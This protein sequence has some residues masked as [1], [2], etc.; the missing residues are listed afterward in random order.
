MAT[1]TVSGVVALGTT[2][3]L[4][5]TATVSA[6]AGVVD[7]VPG[8]NTA[9]DTNPTGLLSAD[10]GVTVTP[11]AASVTSGA[12]VGYALQ[13]VNAGA[14]SAIGTVV[15]FSIPGGAGFVSAAGAGW[16]CSLSGSTVTCALA[17]PVAGGASAPPIALDLLAPAALGPFTL[18][19]AVTSATADPNPAND[20]AAASVTVTAASSGGGGATAAPAADL[21]ITKSVDRALAATGDR[22]T[23]TLQVANAGPDP[24]ADVVVTDTLPDA[25]APVSAAGAGWSCEL[26]GNVATCRGASVAAGVA[27]PITVV[28]RAR[29]GGADVTNA[30][31]VVAATSDPVPGNNT[32]AVTSRIEARADLSVVKTVSS[33]TYLPGQPITFTITVR[34]AGPD[35]VA[36]ARLRD[37]LPASLRGFRWSCSAVGGACSRLAGTGEIDVLVDLAVGGRVTFALTGELPSGTSGPIVN[38]AQVTAPAGTT[39]TNRANNGSAVTVQ[40]GIG[41]TRLAVAVAPRRV[42]MREGQGPA[43][44][45]VKTTNVGREAAHSVVTCLSIPS[46]VTVARA[47]GGRIVSGRYCWRTGLLGPGKSVTFTIALRGD[48]RVARHATLVAAARAQNA[49][50]VFAENAVLITRPAVK[51]SGGFTG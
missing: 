31:S 5:S 43:T 39:D 2:G 6:P 48:A 13:V 29:R 27:S 4:T 22:I 7:P 32:A 8:N 47:A 15:T 24:A 51:Q 46:G 50:G 41:P 12:L 40:R 37:V 19:V 42:I 25:L 1:I 10:L 44:L 21:S 9:I 17:V 16:I 26:S 49:G 14:T 35:P 18:P 20:A 11:A 28:A 38:R 33:P 34:N 45:R 3:A 36:G 23:Y 30:V